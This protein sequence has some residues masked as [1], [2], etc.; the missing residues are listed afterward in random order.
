MSSHTTLY[1]ILLKKYYRKERTDPVSLDGCL[2]CNNKPWIYT[3]LIS[4]STCTSSRGVRSF[5][6]ELSASVNVDFFKINTSSF[7]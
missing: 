5:R 2:I 3:Y 1:T 4:L 7:R 6:C